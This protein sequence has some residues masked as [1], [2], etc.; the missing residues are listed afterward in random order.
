[1]GRKYLEDLGGLCHMCSQYSY[2]VFL[3][4]TLLIQK[5]IAENKQLL[6]KCDNLKRFLKRDYK[7]HF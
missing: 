4:L 5:Y 3:D 1:V 6:T 7:Q 2:E